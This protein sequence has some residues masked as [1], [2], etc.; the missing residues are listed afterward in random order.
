MA[1]F[2]LFCLLDRVD[3][4]KKTC[5]GIVAQR[6]KDLYRGLNQAV[7]ETPDHTHYYT[8]IDLLKLAMETY[9]SDFVEY[10]VL[11]FD[12]LDFVFQLAEE[13]GIVLLPGGG[14]DAPQWSVRVSL[15]N[16][17]DEAYR[18]IGQAI[19]Q[20]MQTYYHAWKAA[21]GR[22]V[23]KGNR[24]KPKGKIMAQASEESAHDRNEFE[25]SRACGPGRDATAH[26]IP[27]VLLIGGAE[28]GRSGEDAA[29]R[30]FLN[31]ARGGDYL[32]LRSDGIGSQA[33]WICENYR[34]FVKS[35]AELSIDSRDAA[36]DPEVIRYI[37]QADALFIAG[38]NQNEYED[39][40]EG[41]AVEDAVNELINQ[42]KVP[43][44]GTS[45]GM[46]ILGDYYYSPAHDGVLSSEILNDPFHHN[47]KDIYRSDFIRVPFLNHV[48]TDT[49]LDRLD[50]DQTE[51]RYGRLFGFLAR[52]VHDTDNRQPVYGIGLEEGA[53]VAI[54]ENGMATVF[55]NG[56]TRGQDAY[57]LQ[58]MGT[59]PEQIQPGQPLIWNNDGQAVKVYCIAGTS[60]GS[61]RFD[62]N[63]WSKAAGGSWEYWFTTGG[64]SGFQR[65]RE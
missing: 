32:V 30:W 12:P 44:A 18:P 4:Y 21:N 5:Q 29:T 26:P 43:V 1:L 3:D 27:G 56:T 24:I 64:A 49:H 15:A 28:E 52:I 47:T 25:Y 37:R 39:Y 16:L 65:S 20:L 51:T 2:S 8:T 33:D 11:Y 57:F 10:L 34:E 48:I 61:G 53:F 17:P 55:G 35:A 62:L 46:A 13:Q 63:N 41:S 59:A 22:V 9:G 23:P 54:D 40:W 36:N 42:K 50:D 19:A 6:F 7:A 58:A 38:G 60:Q 45:A 31:R 14:F